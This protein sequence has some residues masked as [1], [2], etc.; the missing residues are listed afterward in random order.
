MSVIYM[1]R[2]GQASF[3]KEN[4]DELSAKGRKQCAILAEYLIRTE[5]S[6]D[7][8][9]AGD[10]VRQ[11]DTAREIVAVYRAQKHALPEL[12]IMRE[13]NEYSSRDVIMAHLHDVTEDYPALK[14]DLEKLY[15]DKKA[16]QRVFEKIMARWISGEAEKPGLVRWQDFRERVQ[17]GMRKV[18]VEAGRKR[19]V[20]ICTSG[21]PISAAV[22]MAL[23]LSDEKTLRIAWH[24]ANTA[25]TS[26]VYDGE[27]MELTAFN[28]TAHLDLLNASD[29]LTYR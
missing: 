10:M 23:G 17:T 19:K 21:G 12:F 1:V 27:R 5:V 14:S 28:N 16:F 3:G 11:K 8:V 2:H 25:V 9:F 24:L 18:M 13:F 22:Q 6:F 7:A 26:F 29:W 4:Y 15:I 20:L